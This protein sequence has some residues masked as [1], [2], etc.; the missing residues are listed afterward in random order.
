MVGEGDTREAGGHV[1][2]GDAIGDKGVER[3]GQAAVEE[4]GSKTI[5]RDND[6]GRREE[7]GAI[8]EQGYRLGARSSEAT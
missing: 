6:R 8:P 7:C 3:R 4:V 5:E 1:L 2:R